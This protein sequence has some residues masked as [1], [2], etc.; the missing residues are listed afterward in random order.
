MISAIERYPQIV[1]KLLAQCG[2]NVDDII[3]A[4]SKESSKLYHDYMEV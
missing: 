2:Y 4:A 3:H 1:A